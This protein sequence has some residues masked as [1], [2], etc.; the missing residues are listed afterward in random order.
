M[1][2]AI[3]NRII[4][5]VP[6]LTDV[7]EP[8]AASKDS[9]KPYAVVLQG[10]DDNESAWAGFRRIIEVWPYVSRTSFEVVDE[11]EQEI[12]AALVAEPLVTEA[13]EVFTCSYIGSSQDTVDEDWD[14]ITRGMQFAVMALQPIGAGV[15][16]TLDPWLNALASWTQTLFGP[17][18]SVYKGVWPVGYARPSIMWRISSM[19]A[20]P[21]GVGMFQL[22]KRFTA[23]VLGPDGNQE[24]YSV[25]RLLE[26]IGS[27][28]KIP[29]DV[30]DRRYMTVAD[31]KANTEA[32]A[33]KEGQITVTL[34]RKV[35][36]L[37]DEGPLMVEVNYKRI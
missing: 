32:D 37:T 6:A 18:W 22:T 27:V 35:Q 17:D 34:S 28:P 25:L 21:L 15:P 1:R 13:G 16:V 12:A 5:A 33:I 23:H 26:A 29:L 31:T 7:F 4:E 3:R 20:K 24:H 36:K 11:L 9:V 2:N 19:E 10:D 8:H 14:A 30:L